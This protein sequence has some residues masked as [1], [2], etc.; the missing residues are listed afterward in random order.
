MQVLL[1]RHGIAEDAAPG[2]D[3]SARRLTKEGVTRT[4]EAMKCLSRFADRPRVILTSPRVRAIQT[5]EL[6]GRAFK[7]KPKVVEVLG[8]DQ[9]QEIAAML[10]HRREKSIMLV[11]HEPTFSKLISLLCAGDVTLLNVEMKKAGCA[12]V[13]LEVRNRQSSRGTLI[14]LATPTM[15]REI[16]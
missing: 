11:G 1:V 2:G 13:E 12:C 14:W 5:A 15:L 16:A 9:P 7:L 8:E 6:A 10:A 3:D 4:R